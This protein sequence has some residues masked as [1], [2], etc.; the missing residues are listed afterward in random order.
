MHER[1]RLINRLRWHLVQDR[2]APRGAARTRGAEGTADPRA[3]RPTVGAAAG[4]PRAARRESATTADQRDH[5]RAEATVRR[6]HGPD[7]GTRP[8]VAR[9][10]Q[11]RHRHRCRDHRTH[12]R[13]SAVP[14]R[15]VLRSACRH[16]ADPG[17]LGKTIRH[18]LHRGGD[19][20]LNRAIHIIALGRVAWDP[21]TR[22]YIATPRLRRQD[23]TRSDP[24]PQTAHRSTDL[25]APLQ[26]PTRRPTN[27]P[28]ARDTRQGRRSSTHAVHRLKPANSDQPLT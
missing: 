26:H 28:A 4:Q 21:E 16:R 11:H 18:R 24:L 15:G 8:A 5:Q 27:R 19:R 13:R 7:Q 22:A 6:A 2:S 10:A 17:Q 9:A 12:C 20:Q 3:A 25:A 1:V 23:Q 14:K